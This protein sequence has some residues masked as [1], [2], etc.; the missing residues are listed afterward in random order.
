MTPGD[1]A[2][3][4]FL[5]GGLA[6][7]VIAV[8]GLVR[9]PDLYSRAHATSKSDTLGTV[10]AVSA[11]AV[12][13]DEP[14]ATVKL[15]VLVVFVFVTGPTAAHAV[16]RAADDQE[17]EPWTRDRADATESGTRDAATDGDGREGSA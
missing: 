15:A 4:A 10:L 16:T 3:L 9:L 13:F 17:V 14:T 8:V 1:V 5:V 12:A 2:L 7:S 6:F 11:A